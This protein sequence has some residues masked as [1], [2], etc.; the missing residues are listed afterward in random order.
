MTHVQ[1]GWS[2]FLTQQDV[3]CILV[4]KDS[5]LANIVLETPAWQP[6]YRDEVAITFVR[7]PAP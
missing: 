6:I 5:A 4:P 7:D 2:D 1:P 3:R